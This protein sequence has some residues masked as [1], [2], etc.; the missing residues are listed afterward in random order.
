MPK[1]TESPTVPMSQELLDA[2]ERDLE[3]G[4][5]RAER[6][7]ELIRLGLLSDGVDPSEI[8]AEHDEREEP[9]SDGGCPPQC[10]D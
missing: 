8:P 3:Y 5:N 10:A 6:I 1:K 4:D 7:R 9:I 2:I